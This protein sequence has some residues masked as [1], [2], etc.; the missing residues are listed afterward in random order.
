VARQGP[1]W[2]QL[3]GKRWASPWTAPRDGRALH[4]ASGP[5]AVPLDGRALRAVQ[6]DGWGL[7]AVLC[8]E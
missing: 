5:R 3:A 2:K 1:V 7:H 6:R 8:D 4:E